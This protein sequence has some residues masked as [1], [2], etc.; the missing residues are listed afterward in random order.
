[1]FRA[2]GEVREEH[3]EAIMQTFISEG[4]LLADLSERSAVFV[5]SRDVA[6]L[7]TR[8]GQWM[9][10]LVLEWLEGQTLEDFLY[11]RSESGQPP[12]TFAEMMQLLHPIGEGLAIAHSRGVAHRDVK[13]S[14]I[15]LV[16]KGTD[17]TTKLLDLGIAKV[18]QDAQADSHASA[19]RAAR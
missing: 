5:Q 13:P 17:R 10:Y 12:S 9:P 8:D 3:R 4:R 2:L 14:N 16:G 1:M 15:F 19:R 7:T 6:T 18:V 11:Q